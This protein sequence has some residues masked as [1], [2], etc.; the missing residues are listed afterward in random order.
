MSNRAVATR[1]QHRA[2]IQGR[3]SRLLLRRKHEAASKQI[4][5]MLPAAAAPAVAVVQ[6][7]QMRNFVLVLNVLAA[8]VAG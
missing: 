2:E 1:R 6:G 3:L 5:L 8:T 7:V 4:N